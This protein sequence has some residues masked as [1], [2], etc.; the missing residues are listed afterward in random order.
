[1]WLE[2]F[3]IISKANGQFW[4]FENRANASQNW[5]WFGNVLIKFGYEP[6]G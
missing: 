4:A 5:F 6:T 1:V 2:K 3:L